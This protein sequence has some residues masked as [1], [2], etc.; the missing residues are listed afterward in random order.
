MN[1]NE[2]IKQLKGLIKK[3][4]P[5]H[6]HCAD[7]AYMESMYN[8]ITKILVNKLNEARNLNEEAAIGK[9]PE[10]DY[11]FYKTGIKYYKN[12]HPNKFY[13]RNG[14][15]TL[16]TK[17]YDEMVSVLNKIYLSFNLAEYYFKIITEKYPLS[18]YFEDSKAKIELL[19]KL[20]KSYEN[21]VL[22]ENKIIHNEAFMNEMNLNML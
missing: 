18:A 10:Q 14:D 2:Y 17:K 3:F 8:E 4:H 22:E 16:V 11:V 1:K 13:K 15:S 6:I 5:D 12:I 20:Y 7:N 21:M 19:K 9:N